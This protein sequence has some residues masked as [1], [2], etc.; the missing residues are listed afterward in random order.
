M[1][2]FWLV[3][4]AALISLTIFF[5]TE[6][7]HSQS[8]Q[9]C[10]TTERSHQSANNPDKS[11]FVVGRFLD[12]QSVCTVEFLDRHNGL[13]VALGTLIVAWFTG[14]L[15]LA[16][17]NQERMSRTHERAYILWGGLYGTQIEGF[18]YTIPAFQRDA[19]NYLEPWTM[20]VHNFGRTPGFITKVW[21]GICTSEE[22][23]ATRTAGKSISL[24]I[25]DGTLETELISLE[26]V[27]SPTSNERP[28]PYRY[29]QPTRIPGEV[30]YGRIDY[31]DV[32]GVP[33]HSTWAVVFTNHVTNAIGNFMA[34]D[35]S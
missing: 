30:L 5:G 23:F 12:R 2:H 15:W 7:H 11:R 21:W 18:D 25:R 14:T 29:L 10:L 33:H 24:S 28:W 8:F 31:D 32:F 4:I 35:W 13:V 26:L 27:V 16:S 1:R 34:T 9:D 3:S 6:N 17:V 22:E 19:I 20:Q